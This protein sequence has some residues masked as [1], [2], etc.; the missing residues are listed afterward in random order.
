MATSDNIIQVTDLKKYYNHGTIKAL[1]GVSAD[2]RRGEVVVVIGPS[3]SG[4][5]TF[6][7]SLNLLEEPTSGSIIFEGVD[8]TRKKHKDPQTGKIGRASCRERV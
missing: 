6:L 4:K 5:S 7:R 3:G 1:D 8:I 2:I